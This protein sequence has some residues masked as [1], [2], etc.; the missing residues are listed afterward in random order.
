MRIASASQ[1]VVVRGRRE[2]V[3]HEPL[4][5]LGRHVLDV[6]LAAVQARDPV[7]VGF[8]EQDGAAG[9][10]EDLRERHADVAGADDGDIAF[11]RR[12]SLAASAAAIRSEACPSP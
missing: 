3:V 6:A 12:E 7:W 8:D 11:H 1:L 10:G 5:R 9:L 2:P 4:Q